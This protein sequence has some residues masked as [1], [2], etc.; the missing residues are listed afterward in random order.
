MKRS[1][2]K[3][4]M[5]TILVSSFLLVSMCGCN[6][7]NAAPLDKDKPIS[8]NKQYI[9]IATSAMGGT[10]SIIGTAMS[11]VINK[12][13]DYLAANIEITG[14]NAENLILT[15]NN[16]VDLGLSSADS[17]YLAKNGM[18][19][20]EGKSI[21]NVRGVMGG[22]VVTMQVYVL[23]DS[24]IYSFHD[25]KGKKISIGSTGS[26]GN[27]A[28]NFVMQFLGYEIN[29]DWTPE[30][31]SHADGAEALLDGNVDAVAIISTLPTSAV[32]SAAASK[33]IRILEFDEEE[34]LDR[35]CE[36]YPFYQKASIPEGIYPNVPEIKKT[37]AC[38]SIM[39]CHKDTPDQVV[40][41][42]MDV[43]YANTGVLAA[44]YEK[45]DE[46]IP[47]NAT[48]GLEGIIE[49]HPGA[50]KYIDDKGLN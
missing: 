7:S 38:P 48:S 26:Q 43:L 29:K 13:L 47:E 25:L 23:A 30:Y 40:Y 21:D 45:C 31:L 35:F 12:N 11:D 15:D 6:N 16:T 2:F 9:S 44:A 17:L 49:M 24:D 28:M 50:Q 10:L 36:E 27:D 34:Q 5:A 8:G 32:S 1:L 46:W 20:F 19:S 37:F 18:G 3:R 41:D 39:V 42:V 33:N 4:M 14:G 22:H